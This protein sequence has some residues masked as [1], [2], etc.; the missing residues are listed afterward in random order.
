MKRL[1][2]VVVA[3]ACLTGCAGGSSTSP[4]APPPAAPAGVNFT[5]F[6]TSLVASHSDSTVPV[7]V[8][9]SEF[10]FPDNDNPSAFTAALSGT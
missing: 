4:P 3:A 7:T 8:T 10:V 1:V 6:T 5:A 9:A 2:P